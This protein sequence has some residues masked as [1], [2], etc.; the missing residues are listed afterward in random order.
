MRLAFCGRVVTFSHNILFLVLLSL[1]DWMDGWIQ[2]I[3]SSIAT[4]QRGNKRTVTRD[5]VVAF[6]HFIATSCIGMHVFF[7]ADYL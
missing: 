7:V 4:R 5:T 3:N 1:L 2:S 6:V